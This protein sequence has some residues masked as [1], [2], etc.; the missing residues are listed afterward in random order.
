[1]TVELKPIVV[2]DDDSILVVIEDIKKAKELI[3]TVERQQKI[4]EQRLYNFMKEQEELVKIDMETGE[5]LS[6][7]TWKTSLDTKF[8][9]AKL[10]EQEEP[11][12][13]RKYMSTRPGSKRLLIK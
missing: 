7:L 11:I 4:L 12:L 9:D 3:K 6:V 2:T 5:E 8:F 1:M 10:F 13:Y